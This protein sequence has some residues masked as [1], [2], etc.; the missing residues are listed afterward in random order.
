MNSLKKA[1]EIG[2][3][4]RDKKEAQ[5]QSYIT[6]TFNRLARGDMP[7]VQKA[8]AKNNGMLEVHLGKNWLTRMFS[9][10][11]P[12]NFSREQIQ[13]NESYHLFLG[14]LR[15]QGF[16]ITY[17]RSWGYGRFEFKI[18]EISSDTAHRQPD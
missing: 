9:R 6:K 18:K 17:L 5:A 12:E 13:R 2:E 3:E 11:L 10:L 14:K 4:N 1:A 8:L 15:S 7:E 16:D